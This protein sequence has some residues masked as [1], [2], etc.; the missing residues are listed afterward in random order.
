MVRLLKII[1]GIFAFKLAIPLLL[2]LFVV[3]GF[4]YLAISESSEE[5]IYEE[6]MT[7]KMNEV[8]DYK[9]FIIKAE[10]GYQS[11][12]NITYSLPNGDSR[13]LD[14]VDSGETKCGSGKA[15]CVTNLGK[16]EDNTV[17]IKVTIYE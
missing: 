4:S 15:I 14:S 13:T 10:S 11:E 12:V 16:F 1:V 9:S 7:I 6:E 8:Y 5:L 3:V 17:K 2:I